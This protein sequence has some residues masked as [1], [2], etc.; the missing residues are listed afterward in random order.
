MLKSGK[1]HTKVADQIVQSQRDVAEH[2][3]SVLL[4]AC[5]FMTAEYDGGAGDCVTLSRAAAEINGDG[6]SLFHVP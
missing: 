5:F 3:C 2:R 1:W 4:S 6:P